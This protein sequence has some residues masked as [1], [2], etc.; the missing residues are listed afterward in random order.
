MQKL[1]S[2]FWGDSFQFVKPRMMT[3]HSDVECCWSTSGVITLVTHVSELKS[4]TF[5][6][7]PLIHPQKT[8]MS[9]KT[10]QRTNSKG[11]DRLPNCIFQGTFFLGVYVLV[12]VGLGF[13]WNV[14]LHAP[15]RQ[16]L[17]SS[18]SAEKELDSCW[19]YLHIEHYHHVRRKSILDSTLLTSSPNNLESMW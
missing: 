8:N 6:T 9:P 10:D 7:G 19:T 2:F 4:W 16:K 11:K 15:Q 14:L 18:I 13:L 1:R 3:N 17:R 12:Y 5:W